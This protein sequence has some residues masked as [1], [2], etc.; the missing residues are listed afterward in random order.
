M[1][2]PTPKFTCVGTGLVA[3]DVVIEG[4]ASL[5]SSQIYAGGSC[6][7]V[8]SI[9][10]FFGCDSHPI[11]RL[12]DNSTSDLII[13]DMKRWGVNIGFI[14]KEENGSTPIIIH[15]ILNSEEAEPKH[16]FEFRNPA[17]G[18]WLPTFR[19]VLAKKVEALNEKLPKSDLFYFDRVCRSSIELARHAKKRGAL[20]FFEPSSDKETKQFQECLELADVIKFSADRIKSFQEK[21]GINKAILEIET[22]GKEGLNYRFKS[23]AWNKI[24]AFS[25]DYVVDAAGAGDWCSSGVIVK[26]LQAGRDS[27]ATTTEESIVEMLRYGQALGAINCLYSGARGLMYH[28]DQSWLKNLTETL[29]SNGS[30]PKGSIA[31]SSTS[32]RSMKKKELNSIF[33][34]L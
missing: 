11:A 19:P 18:K 15:R 10:G 26:I 27:L 22:L 8:L 25:L 2:N 3:L 23:G 4:K 31:E 33:L 24:N 9:L 16:R 14:E 6:G 5:E 20:I 13:E 7:N 29:I 17:N 21:Y 28:S 32:S 1:E 12:G 30:F 34:S